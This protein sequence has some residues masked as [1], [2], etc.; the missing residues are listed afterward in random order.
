LSLNEEKLTTLHNAL[1]K[2]GYSY[3]YDEFKTKMENPDKRLLFYNTLSEKVNL[4]SYAEFEEKLKD[5][6]T[7]LGNDKIDVQYENQDTNLQAQQ[8][9]NELDT[10]SN[11]V[12][13][14]E[15]TNTRTNPT[16]ILPSVVTDKGLTQRS[17]NQE[18]G[19]YNEA[20]N[21]SLHM[22]LGSDRPFEESVQPIINYFN[23][24]KGEDEEE[25]TINQVARNILEGATKAGLL[26]ADMA[27]RVVGNP[28]EAISIAGEI[29]HFVA[30]S[31][32][33]FSKLLTASN[34]NPLYTIPAYF[35]D[36]KANQVI[37]DA[38]KDVFNFPVETALGAYVFGKGMK[39]TLKFDKTPKEV[40]KKGQEV[41]KEGVEV[42]KQVGQFAKDLPDWV[43]DAYIKEL[44]NLV[45]DTK[46]FQQSKLKGTELIV[47][48]VQDILKKNPDIK[49]DK[50]REMFPKEW[51]KQQVAIDRIHNVKA[52]IFQAE[53]EGIKIPKKIKEGLDYQTISNYI[54]DVK[55][56]KIQGLDI[57][58]L[59]GKKINPGKSLKKDI[60]KLEVVKEQPF[61][62][63]SI[64]NIFNY[65]KLLDKK[66][67]AKETDVPL[68]PVRTMKIEDTKAYRDD[69]VSKM[70]QLEYERIL[71]HQLDIAKDIKAQEFHNQWK[72]ELNE[73]KNLDRFIENPDPKT[74]GKN[75]P[76]FSAIKD[77]YNKAYDFV[78]RYGPLWRQNPELAQVFMNSFNR[79]NAGMDRAVADIEKIF[80]YEY[81]T[82]KFTK[83]PRGKD[84][85]T[86]MFTLPKGQKLDI[87]LGSQFALMYENTKL[88]DKNLPN[89]DKGNADLYNAFE[90]LLQNYEKRQK[91]EGLISGDLKEKIL[92]NIKVKIDEY[93]GKDVP[94]EL[95]EL[96]N[97]VEEGFQYLPHNIVAKR[98]IEAKLRSL[99]DPKD[100]MKTI[101]LM[102]K[103]SSEYKERKGVLML[104]DYLE[105]GI[106]EPKDID[107]RKLTA[108]II[109][110]Y[111]FKSSLKSIE[112]YAFKQGL[113]MPKK[114]APIDWVQPKQIGLLGKRI[115]NMKMHPLLAQGFRETL[116]DRSTNFKGKFARI[117]DNVFSTVKV[118]Q[119]INPSIIPK[120]DYLQ[121]M[122]GG[123]YSLDP[124][125]EAR[126]AG[127]AW[128]EVY[129][130]GRDYLEFNER[131][132]Y[133]TPRELPK[134]AKDQLVN[135][136][137]KETQTIFPD[138]ENKLRQITGIERGTPKEVLGQIMMMPYKSVGEIT[139]GLDKVIRTQS[140]YS[141]ENMGFNRT[142]A[143]N[144]ATNW[145]GNYGALSTKYQKAGSM[146]AF[147]HSFRMLMPRQTM[148]LLKDP[149][150]ELLEMN[151]LRKK[152]VTLP[153]YWSGKY[154]PSDYKAEPSLTK[155]PAKA[156]DPPPLRGDGEPPSW[157]YDPDEK[158]TPGKVKWERMSKAI[159]GSVGI[160]VM[161]HY[162][163]KNYGW[164][165]DKAGWKY[166]KRIEGH[167][168][169]DTNEW[170][171]DKEIVVAMNLIHNM[172]MKWM[173]RF[174]IDDPLAHDTKLAPGLGN[175]LKWE[176][177]PVY[178][179]LLDDLIKNKKSFGGGSRIW[180]IGDSE[181]DSPFPGVSQKHWNIGMYAL[182]QTYQFQSAM[183]KALGTTPDNEEIKMQ[184]RILEEFRKPTEKIISQA[185]GY[186]YVQMSDEDKGGLRM[187]MAKA[188]IKKY[189]RREY[190]SI[191]GI[192]NFD[193]EWDRRKRDAIEFYK[194]YDGYIDTQF[195]N[196]LKREIKLNIAPK[197][198]GKE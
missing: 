146:L 35:G 72:K 181:K 27:K 110:N 76:G 24:F 31:P 172:P 177:H 112:D 4:G 171:D 40:L 198:T 32:N 178:R 88:R 92:N 33:Q 111:Y 52:V 96:Y 162:I 193:E 186:S 69:P 106:I 113:M 81:G 64:A 197:I 94:K 65:E 71:N 19:K 16:Y 55:S 90:N 136:L 9:T 44:T 107:I 118:G 25:F 30:D 123:M 132:L 109:D 46:K 18:V 152:G 39:S 188:H 50:L 128:Y 73:I 82:M 158:P 121:K 29:M 176:V 51:R 137:M 77:G 42:V 84:I 120:Y 166:K 165:V 103:L 75:I 189:L 155:I 116:M 21:S 59:G 62:E 22:I 143:I 85:Q 34:L 61:K 104:Q 8:I 97:R 93:K 47:Q 196:D 159:L 138:W 164:E 10:K 157:D 58:K 173:H 179:I 6:T 147:V 149:Y 192:P 145:H 148:S 86:E 43:N 125:K 134:K 36:E 89:L 20:F 28:A 174:N 78:W 142:D 26:P 156:G 3:E 119:F 122:Y 23:T 99:K 153:E 45:R 135:D 5:Q 124:G 187:A 144:I 7:P 70:A 80:N 95:T 66:N 2:Y 102:N 185:V 160:P 184:K 194:N 41:V 130:N 38:Q 11:R 190:K 63:Q 133:S 49:G 48:S 182:E 195:M 180:D 114:N 74:S 83:K 161:T 100:K 56:G 163:L 126:F 127:R 175:V 68:L 191:K 140:V 105:K 108:E 168:D 54:R 37:S 141:L 17:F 169:P 53:K 12:E 15:Q 139:W 101:D 87:D 117:A 154:K 129:N 1:P 170:V 57:T 13:S 14:T 60:K 150:A 115:E 91:K 167:Y 131:G 151:A 67:I 183:A 79:R 98:A